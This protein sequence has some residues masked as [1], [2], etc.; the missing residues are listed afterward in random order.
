MQFF[1]VTKWRTFQHYKTKRPRWIKLYTCINYEGTDWR[2]LTDSE[3]GQ[4]VRM[5]AYAALFENRLPFCAETVQGMLRLSSPPDLSALM[6]KGVIELTTDIQ[7]ETSGLT[8]S[9]A[10]E[11]SIENSIDARS[12]IRDQRS[13]E[14]NKT[15]KDIVPKSKRTGEQDRLKHDAQLVL[16]H[17]NE[18]TGRT[19]R[20]KFRNA[21][22]ILARLRKGA[23]VVD[24]CAV[25]DYLWDKWGDDPKMAEYV[26][27]ITPFRPT[28]FAGYLDLASA[29]EARKE[30]PAERRKRIDDDIQRSVDQIGDSE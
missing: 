14:R 3:L 4:L 13:E 24:C 18:V 28:K 27:P 22:N 15:K 6:E 20:Q 9:Q 8:E 7:T 11:N 26:T 2:S 16:D 17:L 10:D 19:G 5:A 12:E 1:R 21:T 30:T 25:V 29:G 23:S